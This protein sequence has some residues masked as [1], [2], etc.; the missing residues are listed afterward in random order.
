MLILLLLTLNDPTTLVYPPFSHT[1]GYHKGTL[2]HLRLATGRTL[3]LSDISGLSAAKLKVLD[4]PTTSGDDDELTIFIVDRRRNSI[5]YNIGLT[6][7]GIYKS[8]VVGDNALWYPS[9]C[10]VTPSGTLWVVDRMRNRIALFSFDGKNLHYLKAFGRFGILKGYF[11]DPRQIS[12]TSNKVYVSDYGNNRIQVFDHQGE[13]ISELTGFDHPTGIIAVGERERWL[14]CSESFVV[15]IDS[16]KFR[17]TKVSAE[18]KVLSVIDGDEISYLKVQFESV[19]IDYYGMIWVTDSYNH[20]VHLFESDLTYITKFGRRGTRDKEFLYP[21]GITIWRR[22]GQVFIADKRSI[23]YFWV[24]V[25][26]WIKGAEPG[27][28]KPGEGVTI[29]YYLTQPA[30]L[31][32]IVYDSKN[33]KIREMNF[34]RIMDLGQNYLLWDTLNEDGK[35]VGEGRY[36]I[37]LIFKPTYSSKGKF[38][39]RLEVEVQCIS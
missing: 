17:L 30:D 1:L 37:E 5:L 27:V 36:R 8:P 9:D 33:R 14:R 3:D 29:S 13:F 2:S 15:V 25:D 16:N 21:K 28:F 11:D 24:G 7:I 18:G 22:F 35:L 38:E 6:D 26:A 20:C 10:E 23:Q 12:V 32:V 4:N 31:S 19:A 39:K 34:G